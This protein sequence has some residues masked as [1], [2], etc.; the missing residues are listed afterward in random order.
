MA[1]HLLLLVFL[2]LAAPSHSRRL[3]QKVRQPT[4]FAPSPPLS[5]P[6]PFARL[7][8][9]YRQ[10]VSVPAYSTVLVLSCHAPQEPVLLPATGNPI[11]YCWIW[12]PFFLDHRTLLLLSFVFQKPAL[13]PA[14]GNPIDDCW[15]RNPGWAKHRKQ[16]AR[17]A[18]GY[19]AQALGGVK[20]RFYVVTNTKDDPVNPPPGSLRHAV[21]RVSHKS[22]VTSHRSQLWVC[23]GYSPMHGDKL[24]GSH[25]C[26]QMPLSRPRSLSLPLSS[27]TL[28]HSLS[29]SL[30][31]SLSLSSP[32]SFPS[33]LPTRS[34]DGPLWISFARDMTFALKHELYISSQKTIDGRGAADLRHRH[35]LPAPGGHT[36]GT[37]PA[38]PHTPS[39]T[40]THPHTPSHTLTH[41]H[42][43]S[44]TLTHPQHTL[45]PLAH[46]HTP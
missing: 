28:P 45:E 14:T 24:S 9:A 3:A 1:R 38:R 40:L 31:H 16:M 10:I 4:L 23:S 44:H 39:H 19:G 5:R 15:I 34:Q 7:K 46:H 43:P 32:H 42:T 18:Q 8:M 12:H 13:L 41:P 26:L 27:L 25:R 33:L 30:T 11:D 21:T 37:P 36:P 35:L 22:Q 20:G 2:A 6:P 29:L 17:C